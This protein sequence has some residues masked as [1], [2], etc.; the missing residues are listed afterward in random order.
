MDSP[1]ADVVCGQK[2]PPQTNGTS[3]SGQTSHDDDEEDRHGGMNGSAKGAQGHSR[4]L[5]Q[6]EIKGS[7]KTKSRLFSSEEAIPEYRD[8][9]A[10]QDGYTDSFSFLDEAKIS[11]R[12]VGDPYLW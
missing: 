9:W 5:T 6:A 7:G 3:G 4:P 2:G 1:D 10:A 11:L 12:E 8:S